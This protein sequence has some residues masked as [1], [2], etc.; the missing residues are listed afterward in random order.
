M[1]PR[2]LPIFR[3]A[4]VQVRKVLKLLRWGLIAVSPLAGNRFWRHHFRAPAARSAVDDCGDNGTVRN[5]HAGA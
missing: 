2:S 5:V 4:G 3:E 1:P